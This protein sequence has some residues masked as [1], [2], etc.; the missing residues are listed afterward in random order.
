MTTESWFLLGAAAA[1]V[2]FRIVKSRS[3]R[4][5]ATA[6]LKDNPVLLDVRT[7]AEYGQDHAKDA[8]NIPL[9]E[10]DRRVDELGPRE[11]PILVYC[12]SGGRSAMAAH[13]LKRAGFTQVVNAG[14]LGSVRKLLDGAK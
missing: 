2:G 3:A 12:Q 4:H 1:L 9:Q 5:R 10:L 11:T 6:L 7:E 13:V 14:G 8:R